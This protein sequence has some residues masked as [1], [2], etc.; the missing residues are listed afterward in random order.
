VYVKFPVQ[1]PLT[2]GCGGVAALDEMVVEPLDGV[3]GGT[4]DIDVEPVAASL[5]VVVEASV[6]PSGA[7]AM[8]VVSAESIR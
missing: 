8:N 2:F 5:V 6:D 3:V 7:P 4:G 1:C